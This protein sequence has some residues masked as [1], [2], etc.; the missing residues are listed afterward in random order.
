MTT[1]SDISVVTTGAQREFASRL[2]R[3]RRDAGLTQTELAGDDL[4]ASYV[5]LLE[6]GKR[7]PSRDVVEILAK[8]LGCSPT[9]LWEGRVSERERRIELELAYARLAMAHGEESDARDRLTQL[10]DEGLLGVRNEDEV[11]FLLAQAQEKTGQRPTAISLLTPLF[12]RAC[13][14]ATH[15][16]VSTVALALFSCHADSGDFHRALMVGEAALDAITHQGLLGTEEYYRLAASLLWAYSEVGDLAHAMSWARSLIQEAEANGATHGQAAIYWNAAKVA[17]DL[18]EVNEA[19]YLSQKALGQLSESSNTRDLVRL[20]IATG[21]LLLSADPPRAVESWQTLSVA[22]EGLNDLGSAID[23]MR[24]ERTAAM[25]K[26]LM[27]E[28]HEALE[29]IRL[30]AERV[31]PDDHE[32]TAS[33]LLTFGD[34][35]AAIG[36]R[37]GALR[38]YLAGVATLTGAG[39]TRATARAWRDLGDRFVALGHTDQAADCFDRALTI[40]GVHDR[41]ATLRGTSSLTRHDTTVSPPRPR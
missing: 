9:R 30:A 22:R 6:S 38:Q 11:T 32:E 15:L 13:A 1:E 20:R 39:P 28:R 12:E 4:S 40:V 24:W 31:A 25:A 37:E 29:L 36:D 19:I 7:Q 2:R 34:V 10:L 8:R 41:S 5:S 21:Q 26:L 18:G 35:E 3:L 14:R 27:G 23:R 17:D 16:P 33:T